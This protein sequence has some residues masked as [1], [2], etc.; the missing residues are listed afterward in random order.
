MN[1][2]HAMNKL[3]IA[4]RLSIGFAILITLA[5]ISSVYT[6]TRMN[7]MGENLVNLYEH[8]YTVSNAVRDVEIGIIS[9]HRYM[10]DIVLAKN[11]LELRN[12]KTN[13]DNIEKKVYSDFEIVKAQYLGNKHDVELPLKTFQEW[14][15]IRDEVILL[16][17]SMQF[18]E[19]AAITKGKGFRHISKLNDQINGL[20]DFANNKALTFYTGANEYQTKAKSNLIII[21][22]LLI[23]TSI[24]LSIVIT[25]SIS[26]PLRRVIQHI[27][28]IATGQLN[29]KIQINTNDELGELS[30]AFNQLQNNLLHKAAIADKIALGDFTES[31]SVNHAD[32]LLGHSINTIINNFKEVVAHAT[33]IAIGKYDIGIKP[34]SEK[35]QLGHAL[36]LMIKNLKEVIDHISQIAKGNYNEKIT[37]KDDNDLLTMSLN[38]MTNA[39]NKATR[40]SQSRTFIQTS[41]NMLNEKMQGDLKLSELCNKI[42]GTMSMCISAQIAAVYI[43]REGSGTFALEG[44]YAYQF[45]KELKTTFKKGEGM[46]GQCIK[47]EQML[48]FSNIPENYIQ[49]S[50]GLGATPPKQIVLLPIKHEGNILGVIEIGVLRDIDK[51]EL[52]FLESATRIIASRIA[53]ALNRFK[54]DL[55][56]KRTQDQAEEL[57]VQQEELRQTNEELEEQTR[58]LKKSEENLQIQQEELRVT[59]EE[60]EEKTADLTLQKAEIEKSNLVLEKARRD[61][62]QNAKELEVASK[63]KS[64]F[65]ANM[66]HELRTPLNSLLILAQ[67]LQDNKQQNLN[68]DQ[69][70]S[71]GVIYDSGKYLLNLINE[72]LDL[73][74]IEA[75]KMEVNIEDVNLKELT[76]SLHQLFIKSIQEKQLELKISIDNS[77][78]PVIRTDNTRINQVLRNLISNAVKFTEKGSISLFV[79]KVGEQDQKLRNNLTAENAIAFEVS[80]T[81][82]GIPQNKLLEIFE[83]FQQ[84]DGSI[85]RKFG[86]TG[87]GLS[88]TKQIM[89]LLG[90]DIKVKSELNQGSNFTVFLPINYCSSAKEQQKEADVDVK[91]ETTTINKNKESTKP[92]NIN[93]ESLPHIKDDRAKIKP[94][95]RVILIVEDDLSFTKI[96]Y[97]QCQEKGFKC[98][99]SPSAEEALDILEKHKIHAIVLDLGLPGMSGHEF[100]QIIKQNI[101]TRHIPTHILSGQHPEKELFTKGA[102]GFLQKPLEKDQL[103]NLFEDIGKFIQRDIKNL[104][105]IEDNEILLKNISNLLSGKDLNIDYAKTGKEAIESIEKNSFDCLILDLGLPDIS[106]FEVLKTL[107]SKHIKVPPIIVYTGREL[108]SEENNLLQQYSSTIIIKGVKSEERLID[109]IA[110]FLHRVVRE[111]PED[112]K[113]LINKLY[114][115]EE[116][117]KNKTVLI[118]DDDIRNVFALTKLFE[119]HNI[120]VL[121]AENGA[122]SLEVLNDSGDTIDLVLM[123]IMM[124]VMDG[125][126]ATKK[127]REQVKFKNLPIIAVTAKAMKSDKNKCI[128]VGAND[129][130]S[131]PVDTEK[132]FSLMRVWLYQ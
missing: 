84:V 78:T 29:E 28:K 117:F 43:D 120:K 51:E 8:P 64:E 10:K 86:G 112:Q 47:E 128:E 103:E 56:L 127:I 6:V 44:S 85:S 61:L 90:G 71:V 55:L 22:L 111:L 74:K 72:I 40:E 130:I 76:G 24:L 125:F 123:D 63:Y 126:E 131:K 45:R 4:A 59:N 77:I 87:L 132:L 19:A 81:G 124:P 35:D 88:I 31:V 82:I 18:E 23:I 99:A 49:V 108:T 15:Y 91:V 122:K 53:I 106:G 20:K 37:P 16:V 25:R 9:I 97:K 26:I 58:A 3:N 89:L 80:D 54:L 2:L 42:A 32:D 109:E 50:S 95:D 83:A 93:P 118:V 62:E 65:L 69:L 1:Y 107:E 75:G 105:I 110:L 17:E 33:N 101:K 119:E 38:K 68:N 98:I 92:V 30:I 57:Q 5:L 115:K 11:E 96:L 12:L 66:S 79:R 114:N 100:L 129:Y 67:S 39:L 113:K 48:S 27:K 34:K 46:V 52:E 104:L 70:E 73:S 94:K 36:D 7:R 14:K 21:S 121:R 13:I 102:V 60:L 41:I 116:V